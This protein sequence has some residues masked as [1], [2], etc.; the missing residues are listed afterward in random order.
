MKNL[1]LLTAI[2]LLAGCSNLSM[3]DVYQ[4][5]SFSYESTSF[6][7]LTFDN[8]AGS[9]EI[10][11]YNPNPYS[12]PVSALNAELWLDGKEWLALDGGAVSGLSAK[13][14]ISVDLDWNLIFSELLSQARSSYDSGQANFTLM[15]KPELDVPLLGSKT[16]DWQSEFSVPV[17]KLPTLRMTDWSVT[18]VSLTAITMALTFD[19]ENPNVFSVVTE[20][21]NVDLAKNGSSLANLRLADQTLAAGGTS[22][23]KVELELSLLQA[24]ISV[25]NSLKSNQ[26]SDAL[27]MDWSGDWYSPDLDIALPD[28][29]QALLKVLN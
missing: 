10:S 13:K 14:A 11:I 2:G 9:S 28:L 22:E 12:I 25:F 19:V 3:N 29:N 6:K 18:G 4:N 24:G 7:G 16:L 17:P 1:L 8:I 5:P 26:W 15:M 27:Q 21:W 20:D 23:Q